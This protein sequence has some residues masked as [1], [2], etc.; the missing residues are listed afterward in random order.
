MAPDPYP[1]ASTQRG[2]SLDAACLSQGDDNEAQIAHLQRL[3]VRMRKRIDFIEESRFW[4][5]RALWLAAKAR[6]GLGHAPEPS[7]S[8]SEYVEAMPAS[9]PYTQWLLDLCT[10]S[11]EAHDYDHR[12]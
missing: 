7:I 4:K 12:R 6:L 5:L 9:D 8:P 10:A 3:L 2:E 11:P 1:D